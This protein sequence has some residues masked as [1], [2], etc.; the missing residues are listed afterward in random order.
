M[1]LFLDLLSFEFIFEMVYRAP[2]CWAWALSLHSSL[3]RA[4]SYQLFFRSSDLLD[5]LDFSS[6]PPVLFGRLWSLRIF[7]YAPQCCLD[8]FNHWGFFFSCLLHLPLVWGVILAKVIFKKTTRLKRGLQRI[9]FSFMKGLS[10]MAFLHSKPMHLGSISL[11]FMRVYK[12]VSH[13]S[14][15]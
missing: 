13:Y 4:S 12:M 15:N 6:C 8:T 3:G 10:K 7:F 9:Y 5:P 14:S 2:Q 11:A 1:C